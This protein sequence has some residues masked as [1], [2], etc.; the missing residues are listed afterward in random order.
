MVLLL[1][2]LNAYMFRLLVA[3]FDYVI[4]SLRFRTFVFI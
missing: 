2:L 1:L 3:Q 4:I